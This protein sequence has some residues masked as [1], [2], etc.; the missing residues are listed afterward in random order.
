V[1][2][3]IKKHAE[4]LKHRYQYEDDETDDVT[5]YDLVLQVFLHCCLAPHLHFNGASGHVATPHSGKI[6]DMVG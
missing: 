3:A 1:S 5:L 2:T 6:R 4:E